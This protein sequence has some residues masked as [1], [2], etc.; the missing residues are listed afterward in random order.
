MSNSCNA[1]FVKT[2]QKLTN[3]RRPVFEFNEPFHLVQHWKSDQ[4]GLP[5]VQR[6]NSAA[7][8]RAVHQARMSAT[9]ECELKVRDG[10]N[11]MFGL[12]RL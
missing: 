11:S 6:W 2:A 12:T 4:R 5:P 3:A 7:A 9:S 1:E 8:R 10:S